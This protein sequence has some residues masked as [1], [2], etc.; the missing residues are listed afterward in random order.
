MAFIDTTVCP[1]Y[2]SP[3]RGKGQFVAEA[4]VQR[5][6]TADLVGYD[7]LIEQGMWINPIIVALL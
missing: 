3:I 5:G 6:L 4:S 1:S 7:R 2:T